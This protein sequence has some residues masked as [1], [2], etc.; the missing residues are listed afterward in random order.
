MRAAFEAL[1]DGRHL[2]LLSIPG[3]L[4]QGSSDADSK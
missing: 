1:A 3:R 4:G 2:R